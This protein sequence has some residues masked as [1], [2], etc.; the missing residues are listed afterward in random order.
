MHDTLQ[1]IIAVYRVHYAAVLAASAVVTAVAVGMAMQ[2]SLSSDFE[3]LLPTSAPSVQNLERLEGA[4]GKAIDRFTVV[5]YSDDPE[6]NEKALDA[7]AET[8]RT[9]RHVVLVEDERPVDFFSDNRLMYVDMADA[10]QLSERIA[11]RIRYEKKRANPLFASLSEK[12][13]PQVHVEDLA[14]KYKGRVGTE[15][16][17]TSEDKTRWMLFAELDFPSSKIDQS[18]EFIPM[19]TARIDEAIAGFEGVEY[20]ITGRYIK[21]LEQRD[22]T[23]ADLTRGTMF[24]LI[25]NTAFLVL[26]FRS[27]LTPIAA[28]LPI[29]AGTIWSFAWAWLLFSD[30]NM[31]TGFLGSVLLGLGIDY[32]I[33]LVARYREARRTMDAQAALLVTYAS[34]GRASLYAGITTLVALGS[35]ATSSFRAFYEFGMLALGGLT[36]IFVSYATIL[37]CLLI[38]IEG[39]RFDINL[40]KPSRTEG[41]RGFSSRTLGRA[42]V[43]ISSLM[44]T[45]ALVIAFG[46]PK[47]SFEYNLWKLMP[48]DLPSIQT[49]ALIEDIVSMWR[50][51]GV[52]LV[53][54]RTHASLVKEEITRR[55]AEDP[56]ADRWLARTASVYDFLPGDQE[57]K[58]ELWTQLKSSLDRLPE[59]AY[60]DNEELVAL[61]DELTRI[62][63]QGAITQRMLPPEVS[64]KFE[65]ADDTRKSVLLVFPP[66]AIYDARDAVEYTSHLDAFPDGQGGDT[67]AAVTEEALMR[68]ILNFI[69][70]ETM[71]ML[72]FS[73]SGIFGVALLAFRRYR[74]VVLTVATLA[75][76]ILCSLGLIGLLGISFN[77]INIIIFPIWLGLGVDA[78]FHLVNRMLESPD[79]YDGFLHTVSAVFA[80]FATTM[81]GFGSMIISQHPGLA[82]LGHVAIIG[83]GCVFVVAVC[84]QI[85]A[86]RPIVAVAEDTPARKTMRDVSVSLSAPDASSDDDDTGLNDELPAGV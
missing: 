80:A 68:D 46:M 86:Y 11:K 75:T 67:L 24:A 37:P 61:R 42:R 40:D 35:L 76:G 43:V 18:A 33:H 32:G 17:Y 56:S 51:P 79:D 57:R 73:I 16:H 69:K 70:K 2:L 12:P 58:L 3:R 72:M 52:L 21:R 83:L 23:A 50:S 26:Y 29:L 66:G 81:I 44:V 60:E 55:R 7:I 71:W 15:R 78:V 5:V 13:P 49:E 85:L 84:A 53:E 20:A 10:E 31:L 22:A 27:I 62:V 64:R 77:F 1:R 39:T 47:L 25:L 45:V 38:A 34:A 41:V 28:A 59:R 14:E 19:A 30:L 54:D 63:E 48:S 9:T 36:L 6:Q 65:R 4:Y 8:L 74:F 82:S